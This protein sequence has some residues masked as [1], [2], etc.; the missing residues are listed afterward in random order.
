VGRQK[1]VAEFDVDF[2]FT[3]KPIRAGHAPVPTGIRGGQPPQKIISDDS[4]K[5]KSMKG[6]NNNIL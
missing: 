4:I 5:R 1:E 2:S 3:A 6:E